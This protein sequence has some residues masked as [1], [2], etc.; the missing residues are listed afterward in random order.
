MAVQRLEAPGDPPQGENVDVAGVR[1]FR[2]A[3]FSDRNQHD[4]NEWFRGF[5]DHA[6]CSH[7]GLAHRWHAAR[8]GADRTGTREAMAPAFLLADISQCRVHQIR[9]SRT[10]ATRAALSENLRD[11]SS[12]EVRLC[13][14]RRR[15]ATFVC[16][17]PETLR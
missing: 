10:H 7:R 2:Q 15:A 11:R 16:W 8:A 3:F 12:A 1:T 6:G 4:L 5:V 14:D 9:R 13:Q 17:H